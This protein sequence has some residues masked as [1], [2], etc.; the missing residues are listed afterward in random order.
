[1]TSF[2]VRVIRLKKRHIKKE[3]KVNL[4]KLEAEHPAKNNCQKLECCKY[5]GSIELSYKYKQFG[6][7]TTHIETRCSDCNKFQQWAKQVVDVN[8]IN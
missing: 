6:N 8:K 7:G 3:Q 1:L 5:C 4:D 2:R